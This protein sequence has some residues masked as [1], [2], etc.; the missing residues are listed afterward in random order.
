VNDFWRSI[1]S[2]ASP[3]APYVTN[4]TLFCCGV[5]GGKD[6]AAAML[7][8]IHESGIPPYML[9]FTFSDTG[10]EHDWTYQH[11]AMLS[12]KIAPIETLKPEHDFFELVLKKKRFPSPTARFCTDVLKIKVSREYISRIHR[13][14][15]K[16]ITVSGVRADESEDR[17][18]L[19]EWD[20]NTGILA[21][22]W[23]PLIA[24]TIDEVLAIHAKHGIPLNPLYAAGAQRVGC[25]PCIMSRKAEIRNIALKFPER[26]AQIREAELTF[27]RSG[28]RFASFFGPDKTPPRFHSRSDFNKAGESVT[29]ASIDDV[30][31]WSMTGK[32][33]KGSYKDDPEPEGRCM[34]GYCE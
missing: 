7:W 10:N 17:S 26:I 30:V 24:W 18:E 25:W 23:R 31:R 16:P 22:E 32:R 14:G 15:F 5:S 8:L 11:I 12:E 2:L 4:N 1:P 33:A 27:E 19:P 29:Y 34:S 9:R 20:Y 13:E 28:G 21:L 6:S 3:E